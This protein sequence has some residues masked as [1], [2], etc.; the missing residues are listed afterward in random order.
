MSGMEE[1]VGSQATT[2]AGHEQQLQMHEANLVDFDRLRR[3]NICILGLAE[4]TETMIIEQFLETWL[5]TVLPGLEVAVG[6]QVD[7]PYRTLGGKP[8]PGAQP[9]M[10]IA[11]MEQYK[12]K[13]NMLAV[14]QE[15]D[16]VK[17]NGN[18]ISFY[19]DY[20]TVMQ[21]KQR[22]FVE[23]KKKKLQERDLA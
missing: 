16:S 21:K 18:K 6:L 12:N 5:P 7:R 9:C 2:L 4:E 15:Q 3:S 14:A 8:K 22:S 10:L 11:Q 20:G 17:Y 19:P 1:S 13:M 23:V